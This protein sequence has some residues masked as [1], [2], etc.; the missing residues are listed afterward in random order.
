MRAPP[1]PPPRAPHNYTIH[2]RKNIR[3]CRLRGLSIHPSLCWRR[4]EGSGTSVRLNILLYRLV[5][6]CFFFC[7]GGVFASVP[8]RA[9][10]RVVAGQPKPYSY[11]QCPSLSCFP[12]SNGGVHFYAVRYMYVYIQL[13]Y[14][15]RTAG[16]R[17]LGGNLVYLVNRRT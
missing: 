8:L 15:T 17:L 12:P 2:T 10:P 7:G 1:S 16:C 4:R 3:E 14:Y 9:S 13:G 11:L 6:F 5:C